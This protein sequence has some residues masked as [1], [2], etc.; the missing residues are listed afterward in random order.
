MP[1]HTGSLPH[2]FGKG[3]KNR[4]LHWVENQ[5][6]RSGLK[7]S[8]P[9]IPGVKI[10][11]N[12]QAQNKTQCRRHA[13]LSMSTQNTSPFVHICSHH[14]RKTTKT[15]NP[16][17]LMS[18]Y[19]YNKFLDFKNVFLFFFLNVF[20]QYKI[21][22]CK[23]TETA[24]HTLKNTLYANLHKASFPFTIRSI[25]NCLNWRPHNFLPPTCWDKHMK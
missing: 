17:V 9:V 15:Q 19:W 5:N 8:L 11:N 1:L 23:T 16:L 22:N 18:W 10:P 7:S 3:V 2:A 6:L 13:G 14:I 21:S 12:Q 24:F 25:F 4:K 20:H